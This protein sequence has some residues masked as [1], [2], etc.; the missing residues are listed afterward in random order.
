ML[1]VLCVMNRQTDEVTE[2][3]EEFIESEDSILSDG[4]YVMGSR[5]V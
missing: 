1:A 5:P 3:E 2:E 4:K